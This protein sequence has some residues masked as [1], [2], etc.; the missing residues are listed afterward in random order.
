VSPRAQ[1]KAA[2]EDQKSTKR[3]QAPAPT[4][5]RFAAMLWRLLDAAA[6]SRQ[7]LSERLGQGDRVVSIEDPKIIHWA[8]P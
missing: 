6:E 4:A 8:D 1:R 7:S 3:E 5:A 2:G